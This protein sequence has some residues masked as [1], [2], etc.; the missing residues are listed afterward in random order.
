MATGGNRATSTPSVDRYT[1][2]RNILFQSPDYRSLE[3]IEF[4]KEW[5]LQKV[6]LFKQ[7]DPGKQV[8]PLIKEPIPFCV[9]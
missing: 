3:D 4:L 1:K 9:V 7:I 6:S 2:G 8:I 5:L